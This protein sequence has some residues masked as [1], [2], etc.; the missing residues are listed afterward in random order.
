MVHKRINIARKRFQFR[1]RRDGTIPILTAQY[2]GHIIYCECC[3]LLATTTTI[4]AVLV[5]LYVQRI[6]C[7]FCSLFIFIFLSLTR[8]P[9]SR[10]ED[11]LYGRQRPPRTPAKWHTFYSRLAPEAFDGLIYGRRPRIPAA[12]AVVF[13]FFFFFFFVL[14]PPPSN[15]SVGRSLRVQTPRR[16]DCRSPKLPP[17]IKSEKKK[18][19]GGGG[20]WRSRL[21]QQYETD[22]ARDDSG[23]EDVYLLV[24]RIRGRDFRIGFVT[25]LLFSVFPRC[26]TSESRYNRQRYYYHH[27]RF[28]AP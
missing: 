11:I 8:R 9:R 7:I 20:D 6:L 28:R 14:P 12:T 16:R 2:V 18:V 21:R 22:R 15:R 1:F 3:V 19:S 24:N 17:R 5:E 10:V 25:E 26:G 4:T 23:S 27:H 13:F